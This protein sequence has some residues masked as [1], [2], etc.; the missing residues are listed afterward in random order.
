M[1]DRRCHVRSLLSSAATQWPIALHLDV[2]AKKRG[3]GKK[4]LLTIRAVMFDEHIDFV[5]GDFN[6]AAWR[7]Q[8]N[9]GNREEAFA[10]SDLPML[11]GPTLLW[12][13][14]AVLGTLSAT[15]SWRRTIRAYLLLQAQTM[16]VGTEFFSYMVELARFL[17][18]FLQFR[19]SRRR[20][21]KS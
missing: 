13:A 11:S 16:A 17:L 15:R 12:S 21:A 20:R 5:A 8:T 18:V 1:G 19:K 9:N 6:G 7:R 2:L 10:D 14:G 4:L 3:I